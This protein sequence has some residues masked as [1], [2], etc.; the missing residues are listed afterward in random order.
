MQHTIFKTIAGSRLYGTNTPESDTDYKAVHLP[1][2]RDILIRPKR[3]QVISYSTG[4]A[5]AKNTAE[6]T[7]VE[8]FE[9]QRFLK[10]ASD[11]QTIPVEMLFITPLTMSFTALQEWDDP[12]PRIAQNREKILNRNNKAFVGY[13]KGQAVRYSMRGDRLATYEAVCEVLRRASGML[14]TS[15]PPKA[16]KV[17]NCLEAL[18]E[19]KDVK[20]VTK[21]HGERDLDYLD[22]YG[23]QVPVTLSAA[24]ALEVYLKPV[25]EAGN[26]AKRARDAGGADWK[27]LYHAMRII[28]QGIVLFR[29]GFIEFPS[30]NREFLMKIRAGEVEMDEILDIFD[31]KLEILEGIGE[32]SALAPEPDYEWIDNFVA[33]VYE[34]IVRAG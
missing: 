22:V 5:D 29:D 21:R 33:E 7:D 18:S 3:D 26:R 9:L 11:M 8:S 17:E 1:T 6:D 19:I 30:Q 24:D 10:L 14:M 16:Y 2:K 15:H 20:V 32:D 23:R 31:Q 12:W 27:A 4:A 25:E 34:D 28:E 13:C